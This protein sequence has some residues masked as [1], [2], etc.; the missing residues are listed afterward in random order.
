MRGRLLLQ[1]ADHVTE[2]VGDL[3]DGLVGE[4]LGA[5]VRVLD[6]A[7]I[8]GPAW[9]EGGVACLLEYRAPAIPAGLQ[10]PESVDEHDRSSVGGIGLLDLLCFVLGDV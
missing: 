7:G 8:I 2:V 4:D 1:F 6:R 10:Q 5:L 3:P 9:R